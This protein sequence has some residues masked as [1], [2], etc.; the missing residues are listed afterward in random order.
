MLIIINFFLFNL[1][2]LTIWLGF[3]S[4]FIENKNLEATQVSKRFFI[5]QLEITHFVSF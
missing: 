5:Q 1:Y 3:L 2:Q 4:I